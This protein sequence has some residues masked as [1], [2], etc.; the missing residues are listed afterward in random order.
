MKKYIIALALLLVLASSPIYAKVNDETTI[1]SLLQQIQ[2]LMVKIQQ[3]LAQQNQMKPK[4][5]SIE[6]ISGPTTLKVGTSGVW[7][8]KTPDIDNL[9]FAV[10]WGDEPEWVNVYGGMPLSELKYQKSPIFSHSF[11][12]VRN[13]TGVIYT[14]TFFVKDNS[15]KIVTKGLEVKVGFDEGDIPT[16]VQGN[17]LQLVI[18]KQIHSKLKNIGFAFSDSGEPRILVSQSSFRY[19]EN[20]VVKNYN[21]GEFYQPCVFGENNVSFPKNVGS[22]PDMI[23]IE[24]INLHGNV[25]CRVYFGD[26][27]SGGRFKRS[28]EYIFALTGDSRYFAFRFELVGENASF[29]PNLSKALSIIEEEV[30]FHPQS[31]IK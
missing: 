8:V 22:R 23:K 1:Q 14:P 11:S 27:S 20:N 16:I 17:G 28:Y 29:V 24:K 10:M 7:T 13:S 12:V 6:S 3:L 30:F 5:L 31:I 2:Q 19:Y 25:F 18:P 9:S 21:L 15:G 4:V 26:P